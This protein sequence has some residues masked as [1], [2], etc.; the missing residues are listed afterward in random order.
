VSRI[1]IDIVERHADEAAFL[2]ERRERAARSPLFD[3]RD[4]SDVDVR[5]EANLE[6]LVIAGADGLR[7]AQ[8]ALDRAAR[9][10][11]GPDGEIFASSY[12]AAELHDNLALSRLIVL[13]QRAPRHERALVSALGWLGARSAGRVIPELLSPECPPVLHRLGIAASLAR[14]S[15]PGAALARAMG[16]PDAPLR[17]AA[18]RAAGVLGRMDLLPSLR[19]ATRDPDDPSVA[20]AVWASVMLG[21][22][23]G[24]EAL[25]AAAS[26]PGD[27]RAEAADLAARVS[28]PVQ[29]G[30][31]LLALSASEETLPA[32]LAGAAARGDPT[33]I[34]W[35]LE[36]IER[37]PSL[38]RSAASV[39]LSVTGVKA[40]LPLFVRAPTPEPRE[41]EIA[42]H[43]GDPN[44]DLPDPVIHELRAHWAGAEGRFRAGERYLG[45]QPL[46]P[47][48][49]AKCLREGLQPWRASAAMEL[50]L[51][52]AGSRL[53]PV[54]APA[55]AQRALLVEAAR[56]GVT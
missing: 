36:A 42:P 32:A 2:W 54:L 5:L 26:A 48:W 46:S 10:T 31:R 8:A 7:I 28:D 29:A 13:A 52:S 24:L 23:G 33:C 3:L 22:R 56:A 15:D 35:V 6:G 12:V 11:E 16:S 44:N 37:H 18:Y 9:D 20:W 1:L 47:S 21:D 40:D 34:P 14:G 30:E 41:E 53:F 55:R 27:A 51:A 38:A 50:A 45:G 17:A 43:L 49:L 19:I 25:W 4:L 39:Y